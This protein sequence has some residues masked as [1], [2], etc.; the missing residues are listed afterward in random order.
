[1]RALAFL[2]FFVLYSV[3]ILIELLF[4]PTYYF[5]FLDWPIELVT[6]VPVASMSYTTL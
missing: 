4:I 6:C 1:M 2:T 3:C 5:F